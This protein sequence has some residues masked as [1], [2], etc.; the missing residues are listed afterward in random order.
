MAQY[1]VCSVR[2]INLFTLSFSAFVVASFLEM[3]VLISQIESVGV[4]N[5]V[6]KSQLEF[7]ASQL[8]SDTVWHRHV[9]PINES[10]AQPTDV[11]L[12]R[13][14][15]L[16]TVIVFTTRDADYLGYKA[17]YSFRLI[18]ECGSDLDPVIALT[19]F[20]NIINSAIS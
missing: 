11:Q 7:Y 2:L 18:L 19:S 10:D 8:E 15:K 16:L 1:S 3:L 12:K 6:R 5:R 20:T 9:G 17:K 13:E 14:A 4:T